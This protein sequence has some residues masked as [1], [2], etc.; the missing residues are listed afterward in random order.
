M[1]LTRGSRKMIDILGAVNDFVLA[2]SHAG[3]V[4]ALE[5]AQIVRGWQNYGPLPGK[6]QEI[7]ILTLLDEIRHGT[8]IHRYT[9]AAT[10]DDLNLDVRRLAEHLVQ[11]DFCCASPNRAERIARERAGTIET[12]ARDMIA[13][14]FFKQQGLSSCYADTV[15]ALPFMNEAK[16]WIARYSVT[17]HLMSVGTAELVQPAFT[18]V[19]VRIENVDEHHPVTL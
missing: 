3:G 5:Q 15:K 6:T 1:M 14:K 4:P 10:P 2:Y 11:V 19:D 12:L 7:V 18:E 8:N 17:L 9:D 13:V 16:Q